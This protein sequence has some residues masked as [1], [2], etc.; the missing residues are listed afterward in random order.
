VSKERGVYH[1]LVLSKDKLGLLSWYEETTVD[2]YSFWMWLVLS[3]LNT[4]SSIGLRVS[5]N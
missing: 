2:F 5:F 4:R 1:Y 3:W